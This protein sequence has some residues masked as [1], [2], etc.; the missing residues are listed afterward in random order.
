MKRLMISAI[1][2]G[3]ILLGACSPLDNT[4]TG[5]SALDTTEQPKVTM[6]ADATP[7]AP[8]TADMP[9]VGSTPDI[10]SVPDA[11]QDIAQVK[12][13]VEAMMPVLDSIVRV[14]GIAGDSEYAPDAPEFIWRVLY[15]IGSNWGEA[16][17][18]VVPGDD[19]YTVIQMRVLYDFACAASSLYI[20]EVLPELPSS[21]QDSVKYDAD[22]DEYIFS[23][24]DMGGTMTKPDD[25]S[26]AQDGTVTVIVGLYDGAGNPEDLW[27]S[28]S[29]T[30]VKQSN[31]GG[32]R[33]SNYLYSV[34]GATKIL[35]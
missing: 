23:P 4:P 24:T 18:F 28:V 3:A 8:D 9:N 29:F 20:D 17:P 16:H 15:L 1:L 34:T 11:A 12:T 31:S 13:D 25:I 33:N 6:P 10:A 5:T 35:K 19:G 21:M 22:N 32:N 14:T 2:A 26:I 30:L 7:A 27:G